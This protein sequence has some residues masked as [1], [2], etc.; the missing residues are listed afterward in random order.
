NLKYIDGTIKE[1]VSS[2]G[3][4]SSIGEKVYPRM[5]FKNYILLKKIPIN[6]STKA[7]YDEYDEQKIKTK[8]SKK[9]RFFNELEP[10]AFSLFPEIEKEKE[11]LQK[12]FPENNILMSGSGPSLFVLFEKD[13]AIKKK[14]DR[15]LLRL[16]C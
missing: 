14:K 1:E 8:K 15:I 12:E 11:K 5:P 3:I 16:K 9:N 10:A 4:I 7:V 2:A 13:I 6:V